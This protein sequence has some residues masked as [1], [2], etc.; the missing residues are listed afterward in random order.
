M[1]D[2]LDDDIDPDEYDPEMDPAMDIV[3][4]TI[5]VSRLSNPATVYEWEVKA[6]PVAVIP[7]APSVPGKLISQLSNKTGFDRSLAAAAAFKNMQLTHGSSILDL[8]VA[9]PSAASD[10]KSK[11]VSRRGSF[12]SKQ[13]EN[14]IGNTIM[15]G[16]AA[17]GS[18]EKSK[19]VVPA[20]A[21]PLV[22][23]L[24]HLDTRAGKDVADGPVVPLSSRTRSQAI[25]RK[26]SPSSSY[27]PDAAVI[28]RTASV[29]QVTDEDEMED[30]SE[31]MQGALRRPSDPPLPA[32][33]AMPVVMEHHEEE[34]VR[35]GPRGGAGVR[36]KR[37]PGGLSPPIGRSSGSSGAPS[38]T[39]S[40]ARN[41]GANTAQ[42]KG[43]LVDSSSIS[44]VSASTLLKKPLQPA[45]APRAV[46]S[47]NR[48]SPIRSPGAAK[49]GKRVPGMP[50]SGPLVDI[51][52]TATHSSPKKPALGPL[53]DVAAKI[54]RAAPL[55]RSPAAESSFLGDEA[56][57]S[58]GKGA[59]K[60]FTSK[61][62]A[63]KYA[64]EQAR[65]QKEAEA[66]EAV[67]REKELRR[68]QKHEELLAKEARHWERVA[69]EKERRRAE[70][71]VKR[72][73]EE[74][75]RRQE[76]ER[77]AQEE[78]AEI[79]A[80]EDERKLLFAVCHSNREREQNGIAL[81][82][83]RAQKI[84]RKHRLAEEQLHEVDRGPAPL[85]KR[86]LEHRARFEKRKRQ[87]LHRQGKGK[88]AGA[89]PAYLL[90]GPEYFLGGGGKG[91]GGGAN[92]GADIGG[93]AVS[94]RSSE[95][96]DDLGDYG[97][98]GF[99]GDDGDD[100]F[101]HT[102]P[103]RD[104]DGGVPR[105]AVAPE[106]KSKGAAARTVL[107]TITVNGMEYS[108]TETVA[109]EA[110]DVSKKSG[111]AT[112]SPAKKAVKPLPGITRP[113]D[114]PIKAKPVETK[115]TPLKAKPVETKPTPPKE[116]IV[117]ETKPASLKGSMVASKPSPPK[118]PPVEDMPT[119]ATVDPV[120][121]TVEPVS[122]VVPAPAPMIDGN[123]RNSFRGG[124]MLGVIEEAKKSSSDLKSLSST[125]NSTRSGADTGAHSTVSSA[126]ASFVALP[127]VAD[128]GDISQKNK[129]AIIED[130]KKA[131]MDEK[132]KLEEEQI[133]A[134]MSGDRGADPAP[135]VIIPPSPTAAAIG[136]TGKGTSAPTT[137]SG[138]LSGAKATDPLDST[139]K[140]KLA[141]I[142]EAKK[143]YMD[144][145]KK[146]EEEQIQLAMGKRIYV[147][148]E[149]PNEG[150]SVSGIV[151]HSSGD[152]NSPKSGRSPLPPFSRAPLKEAPA[153]RSSNP[154]LTTGPI[155]IPSVQYVKP[156]QKLTQQLLSQHENITG[157]ASLSPIASQTG[158]GKSQSTY[159]NF[160]SN[161][162]SPYASTSPSALSSAAPTPVGERAD[163]TDVQPVGVGSTGTLQEGPT[164]RVVYEIGDIVSCSHGLI[165]GMI[166]DKIGN[167]VK[168]DTGKH[169]PISID[170]SELCLL[171]SAHQFEVG[172]KVRVRPES[173]F[174]F[175][176]GHIVA[177]NPPG[178]RFTEETYDVAMVDD[179]DDIE[180]NAPSKNL[181]KI[182][183]RRLLKN[184][185]KRVFKS[186]AS[187]KGNSRKGSFSK[188]SRKPSFDITSALNRSESEDEGFDAEND[189]SV[190]SSD[191]FASTTNNSG[192]S[193]FREDSAS[194][195]EKVRR[196]FSV[197]DVVMNKNGQKCMVVEKRP[198]GVVDG[199]NMDNMY[200]LDAGT[201]DLLQADAEELDL[202]VGSQEYEI[203]DKVQARAAATFNYFTGHIIAIHEPTDE[204]KIV[205]Y[206]VRML[207]DG[208]DIQYDTL[209]ENMRKL[210]SNRLIKKK[211]RKLV[212]V[213][214]SVMAFGIGAKKAKDAAA[215]AAA[216][217]PEES[218][219]NGTSENP[220]PNDSQHGTKASTPHGSNVGTK[221]STPLG[222]ASGNRGGATTVPGLNLPDE[223]RTPEMDI[224]H[225]DKFASGD[226]FFG[227]RGV[228]EIQYKITQSVK[229]S[230]QASR[231][232]SPRGS[233][234]SLL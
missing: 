103:V 140:N 142:E 160:T 6:Q 127:K 52:I 198:G 2:Q 12:N 159:S 218:K 190:T 94:E 125:I 43:R 136:S 219:S 173:M 36:S 154:P 210:L 141:I 83:I 15:S 99:D 101:D 38:G 114:E 176:V 181:E 11:A 184:K 120:A 69:A 85:T 64:K 217:I 182:M 66:A 59:D 116:K 162:Q 35:E 155:E 56:G 165:E 197:G 8:D 175:F 54:R 183:S 72:A 158:S 189:M 179:P 39:G 167:K 117:I 70:K 118:N 187:S 213:V 61:W 220:T 106:K 7:A 121:V 5:V 203:G 135:S 16:S 67:R 79:E 229:S 32:G 148:D 169:E 185:A 44:S 209:K 22:P 24:G 62:M 71:Q 31:M 194:L 108:Y 104:R 193:T 164:K 208:D 23:K 161:S 109:L 133:Q 78:M 107:K 17:A 123:K 211:V 156:Q 196:K 149:T 91:V 42:K 115:P 57:P 19:T 227:Y 138:S 205:T 49:N 14:L 74:E 93:K 207:D 166:T 174:T 81:A 30:S 144:E 113:V 77:L 102:E 177:V 68:L 73:R 51:N 80:V 87:A 172:D 146:M 92:S 122:S 170:L 4:K 130:A 34:D 76:E 233:L 171:V 152:S 204:R 21:L 215:V 191:S 223:L 186:L 188:P 27:R 178:G 201:K 228:A 112:V 128:A 1:G 75:Q 33:K 234:E 163:A 195:M 129:L 9:D 134:T 98:E 151:S 46:G 37:L 111:S 60:V 168:I 224:E 230:R 82:R 105:E 97:D 126:G 216:P 202:I 132:K 40:G 63:I 84:A 226:D 18:N 147:A 145:M 157:G 232:S 58:A 222:T 192:K 55:E 47:S 65:A 95:Y 153:S 90:R 231:R 199:D 3:G 88:K 50:D 10:R 139:Q 29:L 150:V 137:G 200:M 214:R 48:L 89:L 53:R 96:D 86:Q 110:V 28:A 131:F 25:S 124:A 13:M 212:S 20:I 26:S 180:E 119:T 100:Y 41:S 45:R 206:D 221:A 143:A 225:D